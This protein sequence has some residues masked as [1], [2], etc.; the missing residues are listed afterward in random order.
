VDDLGRLRVRFS[1]DI[2]R[3]QR[4]GGVSRYVTEL[5]RGL[6]ARGI[7]SR[8]IAGLHQNAHV[9]DV[10]G[11]MGI[12][13]HGLRPERARQALTKVVDRAIERVWCGRRR[14]ELLWHKT[15]FDHHV[16]RGPLLAVTVYDMI[17]ERY[18]EQF[19]SRDVT[20]VSKRPWCERADVVFAISETT[21]DDL[22]D[23]FALRPE[24]VFVTPLGVARVEPR[25]GTLPFGSEPWVLYVGDRRTPYKNWSAVLE[26][27]ARTGPDWRL[28]CFGGP[29]TA[30]DARAIAAVGLGDRVRFVSGDDRDLARMY[31]G[32]SALVYP[33]HYEGFGLPVLEAMAHDCPV[34]AARAG[35]IPEVAGDAA[36]YFDPDDVEA[37]AAALTHVLLDETCTTEL[38]AA[39]RR[40]VPL[41]PWERTVEATLVGYRSIAG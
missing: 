7:D 9:N 41:F 18:P 12:D 21:R 25:P 40:R 37:L 17:H 15:M 32:A 33:S 38:R 39:G 31:E 24:K 27:V 6:V 35:A 30:D 20:P 5:Q 11:T 4:H 26:A 19:G 16:P 36:R 8:I 13:V 28:A 34:V 2:F 23:R 14:R 1:P 10:P 22:L 29:P 3:A